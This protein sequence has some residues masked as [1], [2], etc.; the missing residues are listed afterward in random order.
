M[1][2]WN[3][4]QCKDLHQNPPSFY[5]KGSW[6]DTLHQ[7]CQ[8]SIVSSDLEWS[9]LCKDNVDSWRSTVSASF[10]TQGPFTWVIGWCRSPSYRHHCTWQWRG[11]RH[12]CFTMLPPKPK[13]GARERSGDQQEYLQRRYLRSSLCTFQGRALAFNFIG[14]VPLCRLCSA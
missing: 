9:A 4:H 11:Q 3:F 1:S 12:Y 14:R 5:R 13:R 7:Y 6:T 2:R 10:S 8:F